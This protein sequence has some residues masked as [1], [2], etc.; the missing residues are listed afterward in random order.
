MKEY[1]LGIDNGG[2]VTKAALFDTGGHG[3]N[4]MPE[5]CGKTPVKLSG[6]CCPFRK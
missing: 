6:K 2:T 5:K 3:T 4:V 1:L